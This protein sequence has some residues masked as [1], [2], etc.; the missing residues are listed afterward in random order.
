[1]QPLLA[2]QNEAVDEVEDEQDQRLEPLHFLV[3]KYDGERAH[4]EHVDTAVSGQWPYF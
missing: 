4:H 1:M 3:P 2:E